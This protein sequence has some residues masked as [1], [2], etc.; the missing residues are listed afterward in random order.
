MERSESIKN[1]A[2]SL[3][4]FSHHVGAITK[5][6]TNP[7]FKSK[8]ATL[9]NILESIKEPLL[10]AGLI[11]TQ[12]PDGEDSLTTILIDVDS[13]EFLQSTYN[14]KPAKNDP[15]ALGSA[16]TYARRYALSAI[17][18]LNC[19]ADDDGNSATPK[20]VKQT[21]NWF[22]DKSDNWNEVVDKIRSGERTVEDAKN[23]FKMRPETITQL[24]NLTK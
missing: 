5:D 19:D 12:H 8:Y 15:Q 7:F 9:G 16:I 23:K 13:G 2:E 20:P 4:T 24:I 22:N 17:L 3:V 6:A 10:Q 21:V 11:F 1:I 14:I 18:G